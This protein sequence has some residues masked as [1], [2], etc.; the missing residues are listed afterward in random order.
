MIVSPASRKGSFWNPQLRW[1]GT[2]QK[3]PELMFERF[4]GGTV[5]VLGISGEKSI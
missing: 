4:V 1:R 2:D 5:V 3:M